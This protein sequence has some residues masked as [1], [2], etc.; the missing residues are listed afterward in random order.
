MS[1][2]LILI[3]SPRPCPRAWLQGTA[4]LLP[5]VGSWAAPGPGPGICSAGRPAPS[6]RAPHGLSQ[7]RCRSNGGV[8]ATVLDLLMAGLGSK[9]VSG[10]TQEKPAWEAAGCGGQASLCARSHTL[11]PPR[12]LASLG[13]SRLPHQLRGTQAVASVA[14]TLPTD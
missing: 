4:G 8:Q 1:L 6:L 5:R 14:T 12:A 3:S 11:L 10:L 7:S 9:L 2:C 13:P